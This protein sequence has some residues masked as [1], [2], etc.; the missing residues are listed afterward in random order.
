MSETFL[1]ACA[2]RQ[3]DSLNNEEFAASSSCSAPEENDSCNVC[4]DRP[5][6]VRNRPCGHT[7][8]CELCTIETMELVR[9][10]LRCPICR[11]EVSQLEMRSAHAGDVGVIDGRVG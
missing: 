1:A 11:I 2:A 7:A 6:T 9:R 10:S 3:L 5:R 4:M 8:C